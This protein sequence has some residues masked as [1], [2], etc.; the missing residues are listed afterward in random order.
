MITGVQIVNVPVSDQQRAH[1]FYVG[2]LGFAVVA[3]LEAG[4]YG[5][6]LQ[7]AP[8]GATS[9]LA[10]MSGPHNGSPGSVR[11]LVFE[12]TDIE[13]DVA[14]LQARG[15]EFPDGIQDLPWARVARFADPDGNGLALQTA[16]RR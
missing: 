3:D 5:R 7:V 12:T 4:P 13:A 11:G 6:W 16:P 10:L 9:T 8:P 15:V 14:A 2:R 1:D